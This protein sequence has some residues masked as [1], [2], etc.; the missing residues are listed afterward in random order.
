MII[1]DQYVETYES[2][3]DIIDLINRLGMIK[4]EISHLQEEA[5]KVEL[6][7]IEA[8]KATLSKEVADELNKLTLKEG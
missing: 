1:N 6:I 3:T 8:K 4:D 5:K 2:K 7:L